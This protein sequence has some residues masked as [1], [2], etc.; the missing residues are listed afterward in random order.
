MV[1]RKMVK[2]KTLKRKQN[3]K[4][5]KCKKCKICKSCKI[6]KKKKCCRVRKSISM[7]YKKATKKAR[8]YKQKGCSRGGYRVSKRTSKNKRNRKLRGGYN[9][10]CRIIDSTSL[11]EDI[12]GY[13]YNDFSSVNGSML[14]KSTQNYHPL[15]GGGFA[16]GAIDFGLGNGL[17]FLRKGQNLISDIGRTWS[18]DHKTVSADP[19]VGGKNMQI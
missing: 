12:T 15:K 2:R 9:S 5:K 11:G 6:C 13:K 18:G 8:K 19:T 1:K 14:S 3:K 7:K 16:Q 4:C 10:A 17:T